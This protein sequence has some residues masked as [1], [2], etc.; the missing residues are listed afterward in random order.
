MGNTNSCSKVNYEDMQDCVQSGNS[1]NK[2]CLIINTISPERQSC[3]I[4]NTVSIE[5]EEK[6]VN[7]WL[8]Q[9]A[10]VNIVIYGENA[11]DDKIYEKYNQLKN[12]GFSNVFIYPGGLFEWLLLQDIYGEEEFPTTSKEL[13]ILKFKPK[14]G[15]GQLLLE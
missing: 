11:N 14:R 13:D 3:L 6:M 2:P 4:V 9:N 10:G 5:S 8:K 1:N 7:D 12:L 15:M